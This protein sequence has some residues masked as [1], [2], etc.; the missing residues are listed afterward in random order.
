[1]S[2]LKVFGNPQELA[3]HLVEKLINLVETHPEKSFHLALSGGKTPDL[4]FMVLADSLFTPAFLEKLHF[5]WV[6]ERMVHPDNPESNYGKFKQLF[7]SKTDFPE[8]NIHRIKGENEPE[9]EVVNYATQILGTL[10]HRAELPVFD[11]VL[12]GMG[13]DGH[14]ASIF[15]NQMELLD[16][17]NICALAVHPETGQK[18]ITLTGK[19]L[20]NAENICFV[21]TG[22]EKSECLF[23]ILSDSEKS[24][25]LPASYIRPVTGILEWYVDESALK[26][27]V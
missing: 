26:S 25:Q 4:I 16:S 8:T 23:E 6:D 27:V 5:W 1:M 15:P 21:V 19:V 7:L 12:L 14:T 18:R 9:N 17:M 3:V 2:N 24:K 13:N 10:K 20:N 11:F 22:I